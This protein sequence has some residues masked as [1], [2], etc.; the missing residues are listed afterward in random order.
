MP[1]IILRSHWCYVI[2]KNLHAPTEDTIDDMNDSFYEEPERVIDK[3]P[4]YHMK[5]ILGEFNAKWARKAFLKGQ[6]G[7]KVHM[8]R[9]VK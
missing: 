9:V 3:F 5:I 1:Y 6:L 8:N 7:M 2:V 4:R